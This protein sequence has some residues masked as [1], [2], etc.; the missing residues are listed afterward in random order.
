M[1]MYMQDDTLSPGLAQEQRAVQ[2]QLLRQA[3][4]ADAPA[5]LAQDLGL[6][7]HLDGL[8]DSDSLLLESLSTGASLPA[9][10][11]PGPRLIATHK[12]GDPTAGM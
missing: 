5:T 6:D 1:R 10:A 4:P 9:A 2:Q 11:Q 3:L 12:A 8:S 7:F